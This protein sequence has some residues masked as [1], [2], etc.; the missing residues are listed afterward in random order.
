MKMFVTA[1][2]FLFLLKLKWPKDKSIYDVVFLANQWYYCCFTWYHN[3]VFGD[4]YRVVKPILLN[5]LDC[6]ETGLRHLNR[7]SGQGGG[8]EYLGN[9]KI[10]RATILNFTPQEIRNAPTI[11]FLTQAQLIEIRT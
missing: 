4:Q 9:N 6:I 8:G 1:V 7:E 2:C 10:S 3:T 11:K 5:I